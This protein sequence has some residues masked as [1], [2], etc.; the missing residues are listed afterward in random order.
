MSF[1]SEIFSNKVLLI[2]MFACFLAQLFKIFTGDQKK[3][4]ISRIFTSGGMPSSHSS[5]VTSLSTLVGM[6]YGF[7][8]TEFAVVAVF[9]MI[10]MYDAS[11][12]RRAVGKQAVILNQIVDDLQHK[13]HI[14][15]KKLKELVGHTPVEVFFGAIL[16]IITALVF[17]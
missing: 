16:G 4:Q 6:E 2:S 9:S 15:Q 1:I 11:G 17:S 5:F 3:I 7:N 10:I 13:K 8:S 12:V 14:E